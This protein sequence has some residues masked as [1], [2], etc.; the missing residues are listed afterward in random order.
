M[1]AW[2]K[3]SSYIRYHNWFSDT[4]LLDQ[5]TINLPHFLKHLGQELSADGWRADPLRL[6]AAPKSQNWA[7]DGKL[8][9]PTSSR[10]SAKIRPL[11]HTT[12]R[13]QIAATA[14]MLC[15]ADRIESLQGDPRVPID[16]MTPGSGVVS[17]GNRLYCDTNREQP[18]LRHRWG[19][20]K[21]YR[22]FYQDYQ[23]FLARPDL[24]AERLD[25][26]RGLV[27]VVQ[28]D[29]KQ[30]YDRV[31]PNLLHTKIDA[32]QQ[33]GDDP[34]FF[35][36]CREVFSWVW[37]RNDT[38]AIKDYARVSGID[39]LSRV[40]LPQGLVASG[41]FANLVLLDFDRAMRAAV[42]TNVSTNL[43]LHD[44]CR[45]VDDIRLVVSA[46]TATS[47]EEVEQEAAAWLGTVLNSAAPGLLISDEKTKAAS[48]RG[49]NRPLLRQSRRMA[50]IQ[51]AV[52]GGFDA[53]GGESIIEALQGLVRA[54]E[55]P[56]VAAAGSPRAA[57]V[58]VP[59][60]KPETVG[61]FAAARFRKTYRSLRPLLED[62]DGGMPGSA[63]TQ[64]DTQVE[65]ASTFTKNDL[66]DEAR[67]FALSLIDKW[68]LDP[69]NV[70]LLRIGLD[71]WPAP[72]VLRQV[73]SALSHYT[74]GP[75]RGN[76]KK[77]AQYCLS[78]IFRAGATETGFVE[79]E[80]CLPSEIDLDKYRSLLADEAVKILRLQP[81][82]APWYLRQQA[83]LFLAVFAPARAPIARRGR[84]AETRHYR[85]LICFL[86]GELKE[87][88]A[89]EFATLS[90]LARRSI[91]GLEGALRLT[92]PRLD[93]KSL[94]QILIRDPSFA[95]EL[96]ARQH[97]TLLDINRGSDGFRPLAE[98]VTSQGCLNS[99]RNEVGITS[100]AYEFA[101]FVARNEAPD[102]I[103]PHNI[104]VECD[105]SKGIAA[106]KSIALS[107]QSDPDHS[108]IYEVPD[109]CSPDNKWRFQL[110]FLL[111][112]ILTARIDFTE[113]LRYSPRGRDYL[114]YTPTR[115]HWYQRI[116][117]TYNGN[118]AFGDDWVPIS[119]DVQELL[120]A[121]LSWPGCKE[122]DLNWTKGNAEEALEPLRQLRARALE[123]VGEA[124]STLFLKISAPI[125]KLIQEDRPLRACVVQTVTPEP[126]EFPSGDL[127]LLTPAIRRK[128]RNH[129]ST[130][131]AAV[132]KMLSLRETHK[133][134][135]KRLDW[136]IL[137]ELAV[138][139][140]DVATHLVPFARTHK[141][142]ILAG[143]VFE[144]LVPGQPLVN[145]ALWILP[146]LTADRGLQMTVVRQGKQH[147]APIEQRINAAGTQ[148]QGFRPCQWL[149]G[150]RWSGLP[151]NDALWLTASICYD[152]TD[153]KL[154][155]DLRLRSDVF[156]IPALNQDVG[157][158]DQMA[159]ALHYHMYQLVVVANNGCF[160][161]SNAH[162]PLKES[163]LR[164]VFHTHGQPQASISFFEI[165]D[166]AEMKQRRSLGRAGALQPN[167]GETSQATPVRWKFPPAGC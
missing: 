146:K 110:G 20:S 134:Q 152:A 77:I 81:T 122:T 123:A 73:L 19:S 147:L 85:D 11:A 62:F 158:F 105:N 165:D 57:F 124:T 118:G 68:I 95:N 55:Q 89:A 83:L 52:S 40:A 27:F 150:Y 74:L 119:E 90:V 148:I 128:H 78:E 15:L 1:Q 5:T 151:S 113:P 71:I 6:V 157:T 18:F 59:D 154:A 107:S 65:R 139:P 144:R 69:S 41:F 70:R 114:I 35:R 116:Y 96:K 112:F 48:F 72:E 79:D 23:S 46:D 36:L 64:A 98:I 54:Q 88:A 51:A 115:S 167:M 44:A 92:L 17:Y 163:Y 50:R 8:W 145:S 142:I 49:D 76:A 101:A 161:G 138:H 14:L 166:I 103:T 136:L 126:T 2:K 31:T 24:I 60:V 33:S 160:G 30:F 111:R 108:P 109:W 102:S 10:L 75:G 141:T 16:Q 159:L 38:K 3:A 80:E 93:D 12:V 140:Y 84:M 121:L 132:E 13:D 43:K 4:L 91:V 143:M 149:V 133:S 56:Q 61:R 86:R 37:H 28:S 32:L 58:P 82:S 47:A 125:C 53:A 9:K 42:G 21:L 87:V 137:P 117:G 66:D 156:A 29:L 153:L 130:A 131:L 39:D 97:P 164:Q 26:P 25:E 94:K 34:D 162:L 100:F 106:V 63:E 99:L 127:Q 120:F 104:L 7:I 129:L 155:A 22:G 135:D 45:Y 67:T